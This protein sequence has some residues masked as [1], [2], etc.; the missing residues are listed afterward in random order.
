MKNIVAYAVCCSRLM[1]FC[2]ISWCTFS[3][4]CLPTT[5]RRWSRSFTRPSARARSG[6]GSCSPSLRRGCSAAPPPAA[7][8]ASPHLSPPAPRFALSSLRFA[9]AR[10]KPSSCRSLT[11]GCAADAA[12]A[13]GSE[14]V[15]AVAEEGGGGGGALAEVG[16]AEAGGVG[17]VLPS[18]PRLRLEGGL[19]LSC[20][21]GKRLNGAAR[22][23][24]RERGEREEREERGEGSRC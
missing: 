12:A 23:R 1:W 6:F 3:H 8:R 19:S 2:W 15:G 17:T 10:R 14:A 9:S 16:K 7:S 20:C 18:V 24:E 21:E 5:R 22:R 13:A 4:V 11:S